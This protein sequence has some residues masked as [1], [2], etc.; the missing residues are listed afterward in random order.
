MNST[1]KH[2][3]VVVLGAGVGALASAALLARRSWRVLVLGQ[4]FRRASYSFDGL[5]LSRRPF[6]FLSASSPAWGRIL[7]E[8][9]Q[10]QTFR[11]RLS[12]L[13]PML[14]I[15]SPN[16]RLDLPPDTQL[17]ARE[18]SHRLKNAMTI[19]QAIASQTFKSDVPE[20]AKFEGRVRA[21]ARAHN[22]LNEHIK[23]PIA[24]AGAV[25]ETAIGPFNDGVDCFRMDGEAIALP[26]QQV[27]S[28]SLALHELATN[29][30]K[31]GAL[32][33]PAG[34]VSIDWT[35]EDRWFELDW[36]EHGGPAVVAP[37]SRGFGSRL[38]ARAAMGGSMKFEPDGLRCT[39]KFRL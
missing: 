7:V 3:D 29:A 8:L 27:V 10:T 4:G 17:F 16:V 18:M 1:S 22:L 25:V 26:D 23:Q 37:S 12:P 9:A 24:F 14:Q 19:V 35:Y 21:L 5:A 15:L 11:R 31:Y 20:L 6:T 33:D 13:D 32:S 28:L 39:I 34:W 38:L 36:K 30:V 2:Y